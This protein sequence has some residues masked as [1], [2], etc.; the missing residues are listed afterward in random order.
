MEEVDEVTSIPSN[1]F[2]I[3]RGVLQ[4]DP[5]SPLPSNI[6][7]EALGCMLDAAVNVGQL[8]SFSIGNSASTLLMV[9]HLLF[10]DETLI[11]CDANASQIVILCDILT[12]FA[13]VLGLRINL[14]KSKL[15]PVGDVHNMEE[16]VEMLGC[17]QASL[18]LKYLGLSLDLNPMRGL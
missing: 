18:P 5:L 12:I 17:R 2:G 16:L 3:S 11:F 1:F 10:A 8:S 13:E 14:G 15:V 9:S 7:T 4:G 6:V